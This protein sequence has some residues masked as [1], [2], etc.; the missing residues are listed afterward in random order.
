MC[1]ARKQVNETV[2]KETFKAP[3]NYVASDTMYFTCANGQN[4][5]L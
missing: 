4:L 5:I 2:V 1:R 3:T